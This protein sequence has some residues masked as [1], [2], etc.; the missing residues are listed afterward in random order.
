M[1]KGLRYLGPDKHRRLGW[2]NRP[3]RLIEALTQYV[4]TP[5]VH[6]ANIAH[7]LLITLKC[8]DCGDLHWRKNA[9]VKVGFDPG[10]RCDQFRI[11]ATK[12]DPPTGH[13]VTLRQREKLDGDFAR[14][15]HLQNAGR[16]VAVEHKVGIGEIVDDPNP[17]LFRNLDYP[18]KKRQL[19]AVPGGI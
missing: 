8:C 9:V 2:F 4:A 5:T 11:T 15:R 16:G 13:V 18:L 7:T 1:T 17:V 6:I 14:A 19:Y 12:P 3:A 10:Q